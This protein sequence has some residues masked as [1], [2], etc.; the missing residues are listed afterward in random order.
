[1]AITIKSIAASVA[2]DIRQYGHYQRKVGQTLN[3]RYSDGEC[4]IVANPTFTKFT[5]L[6]DYSDEIVDDF[7]LALSAKVLG[8][9]QKF[10]D[11]VGWSDVTPTDEVLATLD[12]VAAGG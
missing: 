1:M 10:W 2:A 7:I 4:C 11:V 3:G 9:P 8:S 5:E 6:L 12:S